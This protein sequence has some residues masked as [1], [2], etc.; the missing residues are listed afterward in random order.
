MQVI[1]SIN[2]LN[3]YRFGLPRLGIKS[4]TNFSFFKGFYLFCVKL[5]TDTGNGKL[6]ALSTIHQIFKKYLIYFDSDKPSE[7]IWT[8][9]IVLHR[10]DKNLKINTCYLENLKIN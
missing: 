10:N 1:R 6:S 2:Y 3:S 9:K 7:Y 8:I 5:E 4:C